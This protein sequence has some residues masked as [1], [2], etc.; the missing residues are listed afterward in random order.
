ME[1]DGAPPASQGP[2][3]LVSGV[4]CIAAPRPLAGPEGQGS[5]TEVMA[6]IRTRKGSWTETRA[7]R[8]DRAGAY[9]PAEREAEAV[10]EIARIKQAILQGRVRILD[11]FGGLQM[12][13]DMKHRA[14]EAD[15]PTGR[16]GTQQWQRHLAD[17][18]P[19][20]GR[21]PTQHWCLMPV[22]ACVC[23]PG[24]GLTIC[25]GWDSPRARRSSPAPA[26]DFAC[27]SG[28]PPRRIGR[29]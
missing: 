16:P 11:G 28:G 5:G 2:C 1:R 7:V 27:P 19:L 29:S 13:L 17:G 23:D 12:A 8:E 6:V 21:V 18:A 22:P 24:R 3:T 15:A 9:G 10:E 26:A 20:R 4:R 25:P 14:E